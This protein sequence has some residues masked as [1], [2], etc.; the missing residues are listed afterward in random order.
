MK[1]LN[2]IKISSFVDK[3]SV[4]FPFSNPYIFASEALKGIGFT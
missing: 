1:I 2:F 3:I 4:I